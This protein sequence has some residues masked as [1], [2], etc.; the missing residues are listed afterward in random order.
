MAVAACG[1]NVKS[2]EGAIGKM[3]RAYGGAEKIARLQSFVGKGFMKDLSQDIATSNAFDVFVREGRYKHKIYRAPE[4]VLV[5]VV[6]LWSDGKEAH[7][8][9]RETGV[10]RAPLLDIQYMKYRF[11]G[12][13]EWVRS[14]K[15]AGEVLPA[16]KEDAQVRVRFREGDVAVTLGVDRKT[17]LLSEV[18][19]RSASDTSFSFVER[20]EHYFAVDGVPFPGTFTATYK[21]APY[22]DYVLPAVEIGAELPDSLFSVTAADTAALKGAPPILHEPPK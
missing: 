20:Y 5:D 14:A 2:P 7:Q 17:W 4:G 19:I 9:S 11:P 8:W 12:V 21:G 10:Q 3:T 22:F 15:P 13:L 18:D 1:G 16:K 6:V